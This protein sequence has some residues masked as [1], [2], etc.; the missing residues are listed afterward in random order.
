MA[1]TIGNA[2]AAYANAGQVGAPPPP[3]GAPAAGTSFGDL[4]KSAGE[5]LVDSLQKGEQASL[6]AAT[7]KADLAQV[8]EAVTN[9]QVALQTVTAVRDKIVQA[10]QSIIQMPI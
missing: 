7:G 3:A 6:Q 1:I 8:T 10:Y 2:I 5:G 9:A 4:L